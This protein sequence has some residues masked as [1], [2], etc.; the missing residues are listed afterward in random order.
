MTI[1]RHGTETRL[2]TGAELWGE[3]VVEGL[4]EEVGFDGPPVTARIAK[5]KMARAVLAGL[6]GRPSSSVG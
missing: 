4:D 2:L 5:M 1:S 3:G 6:L